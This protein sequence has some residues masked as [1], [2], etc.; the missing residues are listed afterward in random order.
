MIKAIFTIFFTIFYVNLWA[1]GSKNP[2]LEATQRQLKENIQA[3]QHNIKQF[4]EQQRIILENLK[5]LEKAQEILL[6]QEQALSQ[7]VRDIKAGERQL[8]SLQEDIGKKISEEEEAFRRET[9]QIKELRDLLVALERNRSQRKENLIYYRSKFNES[10][11]KISITKADLDV[12][13]DLLG[14]MNQ[15]RQESQSMRAEMLKTRAENQEEIK[16]WSQKLRE[17]ER[18]FHHFSQL[19]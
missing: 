3:S 11:E 19:E 7:Q 18:S 16:K 13:K 15:K 9:E 17:S 1:E 8:H 5:E 14:E 12:A 10:N 4:E 2:D 6:T